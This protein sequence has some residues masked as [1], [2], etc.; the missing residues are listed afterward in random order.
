M[1][2]IEV[3]GLSKRYAL[4]SRRLDKIK[5]AFS[6]KGKSYHQDFWALKNINFSVDKG[7]CVGIVGL[8][9][10]GKSTLLKI[11]SDIIRPS[12][13]SISVQGKVSAL[14]ELGSCFNLNYTGLENIYLNA[15][16]LGLTEEQTREKLNEILE[17]ADI[18]EFINQ[19]VRIYSSGMFVRLAFAIAVAVEPDILLIDEAISVGDVFFQQKCFQRMK[20]MTQNT[21]VLLVSHDMDA[22]TRFCTRCIVL[23]RGEIVYDGETKNA[24]MEY[25]KIRQGEIKKTKENSEK[26]RYDIETEHFRIPDSS[27]YSGK[28]D[29][30]IKKYYYTVEDIPFAETCCENQRWKIMMNV[31]AER[32][33]S[34][35]IIGYQVRD[36]YGNEIFGENSLTSGYG[37]QKLNRGENLISFELRWPELR[38]GDYFITLGIGEGKAVFDQTEQCWINQVIH[39]QNVTCNKIVYGLFNQKIEKLCV[40]ASEE[41]NERVEI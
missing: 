7:E 19:P 38:P 18:G 33:I 41:K 4:Y 31:W 34:E 20:E 9:G 40:N 26:E 13:G 25:I 5:E 37:I 24:V 10:S 36:K 8:N 11:M 23:S 14:L 21:T 2:V 29:A 6:I 27:K 3:N 28:M 22:I 35:L 15:M 16:L 1:K 30:V 12:S 39:I 17:F 32:S